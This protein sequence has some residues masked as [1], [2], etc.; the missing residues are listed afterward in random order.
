MNLKT[1][2]ISLLLL[3]IILKDISSKRTCNTNI[4]RSFGYHSRIVP[5]RNNPLCSN[6]SFNCCT[7]H[8]QMKIHKQW[9]NYY[10]ADLTKHYLN[11]KN[12]FK[13]YINMFVKIKDQI[14]LFGILRVFKKTKYGK[15]VNLLKHLKKLAKVWHKKPQ[16]TYRLITRTVENYQKRYVSTISSFRKSFFCSLCDWKNH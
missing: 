6:V 15:N 11:E 3:S 16:K 14:N 8:D 1:F 5:D 7:M 13:K 4:L 12:L 10:K 9:V 2:E